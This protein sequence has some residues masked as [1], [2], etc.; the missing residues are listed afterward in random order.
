MKNDSEI[1]YNPLN[2]RS[3][4]FAPKRSK[5]PNDIKK[6]KP[7]NSC[8]FCLEN[9]KKKNILQQL[10]ATGNWQT[11]AIKN[12]FPAVSNKNKKAYGYQE[13]IIDTEQHC[14]NFSEL[15]IKQIEY[16][17]KMFQLRSQKLMKDKKINYVLTFKNQGQKAGASL[18]HIHSQVFASEIL[19][20]DIIE[21]RNRVALYQ[22]KN[23]S[24]PYCALFIN[25]KNSKRLIWQDK[26]IEAFTPF[27]SEFPYEAWIISKRHVDNISLLTKTEIN[28]LAKALKLIATKLQA[29]DYAFNFFAHND[30]INE[31]QHFYLKIQPRPNIWAG[32]ELGSGLIINPIL[33][34]E[35]AKYYKK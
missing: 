20:P 1:R 30:I 17:L 12:I 15:N 10:P 2:G 4:L 31:N 23:K 9:V 18:R 11:A 21:E 24:C 28:S 8:P 13:I 7:T 5:R 35:A 3:V 14:E 22:S 27:A 6:Q 34:E 32:V 26:N 16:L 19:P 33:P 29:L 25:E